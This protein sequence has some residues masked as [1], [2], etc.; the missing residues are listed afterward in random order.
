[1]T[2]WNGSMIVSQ[3]LLQNWNW[4]LF[5]FY[6]LHF[7]IF[8]IF[9]L[10]DVGYYSIGLNIHQNKGRNYFACQWREGTC[11][12]SWI[13]VKF[14]F[15]LIGFEFMSMTKDEDVHIELSLQHGQTLRISPWHDL[16]LERKSITTDGTHLF[17]RTY[18][19]K[20]VYHQ[21]NIVY[22]NIKWS[23]IYKDQLLYTI[24]TNFY[25]QYLFA[26]L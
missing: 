3:S 16:K 20:A 10:I 5:E 23:T 2:S 24:T 17:Y 9:Q 1:M 11:D 13:Y 15:L 25:V 12:T 7:D 26:V 6:S 8:S 22:K 19:I 4:S 18:Q 14:I 21:H